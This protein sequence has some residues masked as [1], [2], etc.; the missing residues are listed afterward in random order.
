MEYDVVGAGVVGCETARRF[1]GLD[2]RVS[3]VEMMERHVCIV[4]PVSDIGK[5]RM[6]VCT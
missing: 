6:R 3:L 1:S 2:S 4:R 5:R